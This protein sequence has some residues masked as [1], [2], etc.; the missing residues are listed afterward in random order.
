MFKQIINK[1]SSKKV[2]LLSIL[3]FI[4]AFVVRV[5]GISLKQ[6]MFVDETFSTQISNYNQYYSGISVPLDGNQILT[7]EEIKQEIMGLN[8]SVK[9]VISDVVALHKFTRDTPH[10]KL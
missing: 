3:V 4:L 8:P 7:G 9:D 6:D 2:L 10:S 5:Y 1:I